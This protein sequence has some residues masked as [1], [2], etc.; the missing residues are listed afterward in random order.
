MNQ[1]MEI[2]TMA[3][4]ALALQLGEI[5]ATL[6]R[7][8]AP[9]D[10][11]FLAVGEKLSDAVG[12]F[13]RL[14]EL[15]ATLQASLDDPELCRAAEALAGVG[16]DITELAEAVGEEEATLVRLRA[17]N[18]EVARHIDGIRRTIRAISMLAV[19]AHISASDVD[20]EGENVA[21]FAV[22]FKQL[23]GSA[24]GT[25]A[26]SAG[27][28]DRLG[29]ALD[30]ARVCHAGF[31]LEHHQGLFLMG[32][33]IAACVR[34]MDERRAGAAQVSRTIGAGSQQ[35]SA[36]IGTAVMALQISDITRQRLDHVSEALATA[37]R[38]LGEGADPAADEDW[39]AG[40]DMEQLQAVGV[41]VCRLGKAQ[42]ADALR[43][44]DAE[45][46]RAA[47]SLRRLATEAEDLVTLGARGY[48]TG[49]DGFASFLA[50]LEAELARA[51]AL[52]R[53]CQRHRAQVDAGMAPAA[54]A[55]RDLLDQIAAVE[56]IEEEIRLVSLN[57]AFLCQRIGSKGRVLATIAQELRGRA[58]RLLEDVRKLSAVVVEIGGVAGAFERTREARGAA[59]IA[60]MEQKIAA[61]LEPF[62][63]GGVELAAALAR[64]GPE[65]TAV[66]ERLRA[67]VATLSRL[68]D[69]GRTLRAV[70]RRLDRIAARG[71]EGARDEAL[72]RE[73]LRLFPVCYTMAS[74]RAIHAAVCGVHAAEAPT[75]TD[76]AEDPC[77]DVLF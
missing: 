13:A 37:V 11:S 35:I 66:G 6:P 30:A 27:L 32:G 19:N 33:Q 58:A 2:R 3:E 47:G 14:G 21:S 10:A 76:D 68:E 54:A 74:E 62:S 24:R 1:G 9:A 61:A 53:I 43:N 65:G 20:A 42:I 39:F 67:S 63:R 70:H 26:A 59:K 51:V 55:L 46:D 73:R 22:R 29:K 75:A 25:V 41:G 72:R 48:G 64:L 5:A 56:L 12:I 77:L 17:L 15:F 52:F 8:F 36:D 4:P 16:R 34:A 60:A 50:A 38:G 40:L 7:A 49:Q 45:R 18:S 44:F 57:T 31:M 28:C 71:P 23:A 69:V